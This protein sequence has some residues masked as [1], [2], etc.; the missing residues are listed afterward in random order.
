MEA[1]MTR[2]IRHLAGVGINSQYG[3]FDDD[4]RIGWI[5]RDRYRGFVV[6]GFYKRHVG[7]R[8]TIKEARA[9]AMTADFPTE[10]QAW[11]EHY[12]ETFSKRRRVMERSSGPQ[13]AALARSVMDGSN[14]ARGELI[15]L[16][17][18]IDRNAADPEH[19]VT[20]TGGHLTRF[21]KR[22]VT[23]QPDNPT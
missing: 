19:Q 21:A 5:G 13:I 22:Q 16:L 14:E 18:E 7:R 11:Q 6:E 12:D 2:E 15:D 1:T 23:D 8:T 17:A 10:Q 20:Y 9:F 3:V 4:K